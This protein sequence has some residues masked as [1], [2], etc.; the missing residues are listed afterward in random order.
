MHTG[1][2]HVATD[3]G[4]GDPEPENIDAGINGGSGFGEGGAGA[5]HET[6]GCSSETFFREAL[7][8]KFF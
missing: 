2:I 1:R 4:G 8:L 6:G 7:N 5:G 3:L